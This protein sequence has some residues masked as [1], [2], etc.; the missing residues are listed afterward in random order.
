MIGNWSI[1]PLMLKLHSYMQC[2][3]VSVYVVLSSPWECWFDASS[4]ADLKVWELKFLR[5]AQGF[6]LFSPFSISWKSS[7]CLCCFW[8]ISF[9]CIFVI[10]VGAVYWKWLLSLVLSFRYLWIPNSCLTH[11]LQE[12]NQ[13]AVWLLT[14]LFRFEE[15]LHQ[16]LAED[17]EPL[18]DLMGFPLYLPQSLISTP[19]LAGPLIKSPMSSVQ[20]VRQGGTEDWLWRVLCGCQTSCNHRSSVA[21]TLLCSVA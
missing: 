11:W 5:L 15:Q 8:A 13:A 6:P 2:S 20:V 21:T 16:Y 10:A 1:K 9:N 3:V 14:F 17:I 18:G 4:N 7:V 19:T 12:Q